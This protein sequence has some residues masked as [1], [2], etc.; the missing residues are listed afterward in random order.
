MSCPTLRFSILSL[1]ERAVRGRA[2]HGG[3]VRCARGSPHAALAASLLAGI[4]ALAISVGGATAT[5]GALAAPN[6]DATVGFVQGVLLGPHESV[7]FH[8]KD[9]SKSPLI[10]G[11][12]ADP[13]L[14][15]WDVAAGEE[16]A[17]GADSTVVGPGNTPFMTSEAS[18]EFQN[19][20]LPKLYW[21]IV[22]A[23]GNAHGITDLYGPFYSSETATGM[24]MATGTGK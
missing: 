21:L 16:V 9:S 19:G 12:K 6:V 15:L 24:I 5:A 2:S 17:F 8:T 22:R 7:S 3:A 14:H 1:A 13:A 23:E 11:G 20:P 10:P 4:G 18:L